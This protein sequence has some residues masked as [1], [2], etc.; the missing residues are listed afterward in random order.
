MH[1]T[2][3]EME[4]WNR[5]KIYT[6]SERYVKLR[7]EHK[8]CINTVQCNRVI[9]VFQTV[10][11]HYTIQCGQRAYR[12]YCTRAKIGKVFRFIQ[13]VWS[14]Y[15]FIVHKIR[16]PIDFIFIHCILDHFRHFYYRTCSTCRNLIL[17]IDDD[18]ILTF[19]IHN[20]L[21]HSS[22]EVKNDVCKY[23]RMKE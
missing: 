18:S 2:S 21:K 13:Q 16:D 1:I 9:L 15:L 7:V 23:W 22:N 4:M 19:I 8:L 12:K 17:K 10:F 5:N 6:R 14:T 3:N 11:I 20:V